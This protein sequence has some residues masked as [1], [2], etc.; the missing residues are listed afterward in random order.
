MSSFSA[1]GTG[2][3]FTVLET[4]FN[5]KG[6]PL[7][8]FTCQILV[9]SATEWGA[10]FSL[11]SWNV[12]LRPIPGGNTVYV[13]IGGGAGEGTLSIDDLNGGGAALSH[14]AV[15]TGLSRDYVEPGSIRTRATATWV[16]TN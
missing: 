9:N 2:V 8:E 11:R 1:G 15:M 12:S 7:E 4:A 3:S 13:D 5:D 10:L 6:G 16:I 14:K